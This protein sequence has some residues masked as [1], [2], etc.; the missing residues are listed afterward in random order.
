MSKLNKD[1]LFLI[2]D[3]LQDDSKSLFSCLMV[4]RIWCET[5]IPILWKNP[6]CYDINYNKDYLF[7]IITS[8][9]SDDIKEFLTSQSIR[10]P[11]FSHHSLL[12]DYLSF[13]R[14]INVNTINII[15]SIG[16][17]SSY[18]QFLLQQEFYGLFMKKFPELKYLDMKSIKHQIFYFP[19]AR[20]RFESLF[21]LT[22]DTLINFSYFYGLAQ[23][24]QYIQRLIIVNLDPNN[25]HGIAK[26][27]GVQ[28]NLKYFEWK[29]EH[30][31]YVPRLDSYKK[32]LLAL[33]KN[34]NTI[35]DLKIHFTFVNN[36]TLPKVLPKFHK[37]KTLITRFDNFNE[38][39]LKMC[40]YH[41]LEIF[42]IDYHYLKA[43][44][45]IVENSGGHIKKILLGPFNAY[46]DNIG[47]DSLIFIRNIHKNCPLIEYLPLI[48]P[49][50]KKHF[51]EIEELLKICQNLKLLLLIIYDYSIYEESIYD[52]KILEYGENLLKILIS[53]TLSNI[54]EIRFCG[55]FKF[56]LVALEKF[57]ETW[58]G[59]ALSILTSNYTYEE[60]DYKKLINK[61]KNNGVIK[62]FRCESYTNVANMDFK[63]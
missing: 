22:C 45:I 62:D 15:T 63:I 42:K 4:N 10:L 41:D 60:E 46:A 37:L 16:S 36:H 47:E 52:E 48:F 1:I 59:N 18:N 27:I 33:E 6:W 3:E 39:Q 8:Y 31:L 30:E 5:G 25:Y 51:V 61:Y 29:D 53:S 14:S 23:L 20:F 55:V 17:T 40:V 2:F 21:E 43:A 50:T 28:K 38:E 54:K 9:L 56:S 11:A 44:S 49:P 19:E 35:T 34:A 32:I 58:K 12:F 24:C 26:L 57:L 7:N 13:C